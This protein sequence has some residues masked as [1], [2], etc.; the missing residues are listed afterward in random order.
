MNALHRPI[1]LVLLLLI[2]L[3]AAPAFANT[4]HLTMLAEERDSHLA[5]QQEMIALYQ[6]A[7]PHV[8]IEL[9]SAAGGVPLDI[10]WMDPWV[11]VS[12]A[13]EG[14][15]EDLAPYIAREPQQFQDWYPALWDLYRF[16]EGIYALPQDIQIAGI[17]YN[18]DAY[19]RAGL[20]LPSEYWT[21]EDLSENARRMTVRDG[22]G[23]I[24][25]HGFK[26][27]TGRNWVPNVWAYGGD[28]VDS[29]TQPTRFT[30]NT[31]E[32]AAALEYW[33]SL[34]QFDAVQDAQTHAAQGVI[35]AFMS[36]SIAMG[37]TNTIVFGDFNQITDF[38]WDVAP[39]PNGPQGRAPFI[40]AI[41]W[42]MFS[43][44]P[45]KD[46]AWDV[47]RF[48]TTQ[49]ALRR[50]VEIIGNVSPSM[51]VVQTAWLPSLEM[52]ANRHLLLTDMH[53]AKSPWPLHSDFWNPI[54]RESLDV[55]WG[56]KPAR[57]ALETMEAQVNAI[58]AEWAAR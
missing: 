57:S 1:G 18:V 26:I 29:W 47:L 19:E 10:G 8:E 23:D 20:P 44:S 48:F 52:P 4:I 54:N 21:Y 45:H 9:V 53:L 36:N 17:F 33:H 49:E 24:I 22:G 2:G 16:D 31:P 3:M 27:P 55:I 50:R 41:G 43:T 34:V 30:G 39:L 5:W 38:A 15:L 56:R 6:A 28:F 14:L 42:F 12:F 58:I 35:P 11:V 13:R 25:R 51:G 37:L 32:T 46:V 7:N 40:N